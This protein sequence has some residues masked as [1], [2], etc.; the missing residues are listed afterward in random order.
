MHGSPPLSPR[1][2]ENPQYSLTL[3]RVDGPG[4]YAGATHASPLRRKATRAR[5]CGPLLPSQLSFSIPDCLAANLSVSRWQ[6]CC[7]T[8]VCSGGNH[9]TSG[10]EQPRAEY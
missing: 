8:W 9:G 4:T 6:L 2:H 3:T 5:L 1:L 10:N 7:T